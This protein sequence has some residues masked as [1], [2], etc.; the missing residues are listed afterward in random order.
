MKILLD[1]DKD[2]KSMICSPNPMIISKVDSFN[3]NQLAG[4]I[5]NIYFNENTISKIRIKGNSQ[6]LFVITDEKTEDKIGF[7]ATKCSEIS[8]YFKENKIES[9]N[10]NIKPIS[11]ITPYDEIKEKDKYLEGFI[12]KEL[13]QQSIKLKYLIYN[14]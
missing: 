2:L 14:K 10:Y 6:S 11:T 8:L 9:I 13:D 3:Y 7:N 4:N 12:W 1:E 5:M